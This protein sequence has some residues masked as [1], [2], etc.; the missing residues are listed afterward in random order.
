MP[1]LLSEEK[2]KEEKVFIDFLKE[3]KILTIF[4]NG[5]KKNIASRD[6]RSI[7]KIV[8][9]NNP[10]MFLCAIDWWG[11]IQGHGFW[12]ELDTKWE[13]YYPTKGIIDA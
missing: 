12:S 9:Y 1:K 8:F 13:E 6:E 5:I 2:Q 3:H 4:K 11:S 7:K 10:Y